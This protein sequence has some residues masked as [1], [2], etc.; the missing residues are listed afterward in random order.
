MTP[1]LSFHAHEHNFRTCKLARY[2][3]YEYFEYHP[4]LSVSLRMWAGIFNRQK[5]LTRP[6]YVISLFLLF[7]RTYKNQEMKFCTAQSKL[8]TQSVDRVY[9]LGGELPSSNN[10]SDSYMCKNYVDSI[11]LQVRNSELSWREAKRLLRK[12]H[13][14]DLADLLDR[15]E[16]EK[17]FNEHIEQLT[18]KKR[19]KFRLVI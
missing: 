3:K 4:E 6:S 12:D 14:W 5:T 19:E 10:V 9:V 17:L 15:D 7:C 2:N 1:V 8:Q 13:R 11:Y 18:K 16:K